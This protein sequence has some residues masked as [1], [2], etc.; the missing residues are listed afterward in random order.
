M[1][2]CKICGKELKNPESPRHINSKYHQKKLKELKAKKGQKSKGKEELKTSLN[3]N[4]ILSII[5]RL[6]RIEHRLQVLEKF[7]HEFKNKESRST[8]SSVS[9][10]LEIVKEKLPIISKNQLGIEKV[11]L[12]ELYT[13]ITDEYSISKKNFSKGLLKLNDA[14]KVQLEPGSSSRDFSINDNYGNVYKLIRLLK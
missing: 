10:L 13:K 3:S 12:G 9:A 4:D 5:D 7:H 14:G 6:D 1:P 8:I 11:S 2:I